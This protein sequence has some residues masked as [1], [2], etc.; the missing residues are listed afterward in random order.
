MTNLKLYVWEDVLC[1][2]SCGMACVLAESEE[3]ALKLL[4]ETWPDMWKYHHEEF[5]GVDPDVYEVPV[6]VYSRGGA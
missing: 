5:E 2:Y 3:A 1:D 6:A 4:A